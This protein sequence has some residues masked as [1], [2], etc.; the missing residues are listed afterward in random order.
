MRGEEVREGSCPI[1]LN[2]PMPLAM[3]IVNGVSDGTETL[4]LAIDLYNTHVTQI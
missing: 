3:V 1:F 2:V 4:C